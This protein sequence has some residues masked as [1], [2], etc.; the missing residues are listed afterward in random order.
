M[1][2]LSVLC[3]AVLAATPASFADAETWVLG[4]GAAD[5][6]HAGTPSVPSLTLEWH[7]KPF[8]SNHGWHVAPA[9]AAITDHR[10]DGWLGI[11]L[12]ANYTFGR[13]FVEVSEL[14]GYYHAGEVSSVLGGPLEFRSLL[15]LGYRLTDR[16]SLSLALYHRSNADIYSPNPG[17]NTVTL[18]L[19]KAF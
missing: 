1:R 5:Y 16:A 3:L 18:R 14:P 19:E 8:W 10:H 12:V 17:V 7:G 6:G 2:I 4:Y 9:I 11:G 15:G 13:W